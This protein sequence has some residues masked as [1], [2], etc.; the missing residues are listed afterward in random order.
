MVRQQEIQQLQLDASRREAEQAAALQAEAHAA[1]VFAKLCAYQQVQAEREKAQAVASAKA[2]QQMVELEKAQAVESTTAAQQMV[3]LQQ[4]LDTANRNKEKLN[5]D[6]ACRR[7]RS[8]STS[9]E[10]TRHRSRSRSHQHAEVETNAQGMLLD[11][12]H[13]DIEATLVHMSDVNGLHAVKDL[14][15]VDEPEQLHIHQD[16][17]DDAHAHVLSPERKKR[18]A[19]LAEKYGATPPASQSADMMIVAIHDP[20]DIP[21][22]SDED[23]GLGR[24]LDASEPS[25]KFLRLIDSDDPTLQNASNQVFR[26]ASLL[27][28]PD[29]MQQALLEEL[30]MQVVEL[31]ESQQETVDLTH[32]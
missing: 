11:V 21:I 3:E 25:K 31:M 16:Y 32:N 19:A 5:K 30:P 18:V 6:R 13:A 27:V 26:V 10:S 14:K 7:G 12:D 28:P 20:T 15:D 23:I 4:A 8:T 22:D 2:A 29:L 1:D 24:D 17:S 9:K